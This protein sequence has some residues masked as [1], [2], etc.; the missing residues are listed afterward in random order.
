MD[1]NDDAYRTLMQKPPRKKKWKKTKIFAWITV[2][3]SI[4]MTIRAMAESISAAD[5]ASAN[6]L[7]ESP[8]KCWA[9]GNNKWLCVILLITTAYANCRIVHQ[10]K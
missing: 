1:D 6:P 9:A 3:R 5:S 7:T 10:L 2:F 4:Q 8:K